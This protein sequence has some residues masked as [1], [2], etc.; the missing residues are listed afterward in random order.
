MFETRIPVK[1]A[2]V[3]RLI[4]ATFPNFR[5]RKIYREVTDRV[6][7]HD[8]NWSGGT[9]NV[10]RSCTIAGTPV[11]GSDKYGRMAPWENPAEGAT[12]PL[13]AGFV[14]VCSGEFQGRST[15]LTIYVHPDDLTP[16][17]PPAA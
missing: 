3:A 11:G 13:P 7:L 2:E 10:Y 6:L 16:E 5:G 14:V 4:A 15:G 8:L 9:R 17:L 12:L 1:R